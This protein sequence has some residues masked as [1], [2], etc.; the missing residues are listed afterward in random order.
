[1]NGRLRRDSMRCAS[2]MGSRDRVKFAE[3][4]SA[5]T[6]SGGRPCLKEAN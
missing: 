3:E 4:N 1:M 6:E 5:S 2:R